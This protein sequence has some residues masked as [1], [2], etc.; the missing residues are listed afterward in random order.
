MA[1]PLSDARIEEIVK[2]WGRRGASC[3]KVAKW[4]RCDEGLALKYRPDADPADEL[5][6]AEERAGRARELAVER[7]ALQAVAG[8][9][10][11][12]AFLDSLVRD[13]VPAIDPPP[14]YRE[15]KRA[16]RRWTNR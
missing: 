10:S 4:C 12:R 6:T 1:A 3:R 8:E 15:P 14:K 13:A 7:E 2:A 11:F 5:R 9:R 16:S